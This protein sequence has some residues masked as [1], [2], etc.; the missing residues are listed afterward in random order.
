[1]AGKASKNKLPKRQRAL[2][3][4][5]WTL[6]LMAPETARSSHK[7]YVLEH[8]GEDEIAAVQAWIGIDKAARTTPELKAL[9]KALMGRDFSNA[10]IQIRAFAD[11]AAAAEFVSHHEILAEAAQ[12]PQGQ[13]LA[14]LLA[15]ATA[16]VASCE[17]GFPLS[18]D[19][20]T[21]AQCLAG[22]ATLERMAEDGNACACVALDQLR[23]IEAP[24]TLVLAIDAA[25]TRRGLS[26]FADAR[27]LIPGATLST[28]GVACRERH[29]C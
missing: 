20:D 28:Y 11:D 14:H 16:P 15:R 13:D 1:M 17:A 12:T 4:L 3:S 22:I 29:G 2:V 23:A 8:G 21:L 5:A 24:L 19:A 26:R 25:I 9:V 6:A 18:P 27:H 7:G 10:L